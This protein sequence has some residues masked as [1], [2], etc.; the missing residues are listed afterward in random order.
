MIS[1]INACKQNC[2]TA[3]KTIQ[4]EM[5]YAIKAGMPY[6]TDVWNNYNQKL[7]NAAARAVISNVQD[8]VQVVSF[9]SFLKEN[10]LNYTAVIQTIYG[11][12]TIQ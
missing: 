1:G 12:V 2:E 4:G 8:V 3:M 9:S 7:F 10:I 11:T 5:M 6:Q